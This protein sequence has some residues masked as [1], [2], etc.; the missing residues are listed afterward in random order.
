MWF[1][2]I[3]CLAGFA[4]ESMATELKWNGFASMYA[5]DALDKD[6]RDVSTQSK[7]IG[8]TNDSKFGLNLR[9][10]IDEEWSAVG[11]LVVSQ[12]A[13]GPSG[14]TPNW[15]GEFDWFFLSY[16]NL[17]YGFEI[18]AGRQ[19]FP[20]TLT[21]EYVDV[22]ITYPWRRLP[23]QFSAISQFKSFE[24]VSVSKKYQI[25]DVNIDGRVFGGNGKSNLQ[26]TGIATVDITNMTGA[27]LSAEGDGWKIQ[28]TYTHLT[29]VYQTSP[30]TPVSPGLPTMEIP[31]T[32]LWVLGG[33]Y[34]RGGLVTYAEYGRSR[35]DDNTIKVSGY[36]GMIGYHVGRFLPH[37][38]YA[39][40]DWK[41]N[42][43]FL[44]AKEISHNYGLNYQLNP[45]IVLKVEYLRQIDKRGALFLT[46]AD[47]WA[48]SVAVGINAVF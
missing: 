39:M 22:G 32:N 8:T 33:R 25:A 9:A 2:G 17:D 1:V 6:T 28:S 7:G 5:R 30:F 46:K 45:S 3:F 38:T 19:L 11:Q 23:Q 18:K 34:D 20:S 27:L 41:L 13:Y 26:P 15:G 29:V 47:S 21:A 43:F 48:D 4:D 35:N 42:P 16:R 44:D 37:Y 14:E 12:K 31:K 40:A 24:G 10:D 36:Y